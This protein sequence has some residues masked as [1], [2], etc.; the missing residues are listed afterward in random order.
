[1]LV[2]QR[3]K[4]WNHPIETNIYKRMFQVPGNTANVCMVILG[5]L[6]LH[7]VHPQISSLFNVDSG[8]N[9]LDRPV[10]RGVPGEKLPGTWMSR[11]SLNG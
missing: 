4:I 5:D 11:M 2:Y 9:F 1:M 10:V 7:F 8:F 3:V 6:P